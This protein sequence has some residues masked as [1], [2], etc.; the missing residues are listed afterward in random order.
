M[1]TTRRAG[2]WFSFLFGKAAR[3][4]LALGFRRIGTYTLARESGTSLRAAGW[5]LLGQT[6]GGSWSRP[7]RERTDKHPTEQKLLWEIGA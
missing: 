3:A 2:F 1:T 4:A 5:T 7:G 6:K